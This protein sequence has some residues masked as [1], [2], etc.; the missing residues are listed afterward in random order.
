[1]GFRQF[2]IADHQ[3]AESLQRHPAV[4]RA[5]AMGRFQRICS[6]MPRRE[7]HQVKKQPQQQR[8]PPETLPQALSQ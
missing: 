4:H 7:S 5:T 3:L 2:A 8:M 1:V 6:N